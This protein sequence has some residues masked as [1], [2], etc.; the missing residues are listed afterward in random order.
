MTKIYSS[1][2][3][4][5]KCFANRKLKSLQNEQSYS[6]IVLQTFDSLKA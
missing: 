3:I 5:K 6:S 2:K 4:H 1:Q